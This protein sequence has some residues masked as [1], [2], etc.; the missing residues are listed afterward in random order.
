MEKHLLPG[1]GVVL[2]YMAEVKLPPKEYDLNFVEMSKRSGALLALL[3]LLLFVSPSLDV[4][5]SLLDLIDCSCLFLAEDTYLS[6]NI[7]VLPV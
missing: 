5:L 4:C 3:G 1:R 7:S 2:P 6:L